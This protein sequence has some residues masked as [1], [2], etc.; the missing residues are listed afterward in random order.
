MT[1]MELEIAL[2]RRETAEPL[3]QARIDE[4]VATYGRHPTI[5]FFNNIT[6]R[7]LA[8]W[9]GPMDGW[10]VEAGLIPRESGFVLG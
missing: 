4:F 2:S 8:K 9:H 7:D 10:N 6:V 5:M 3:V 1:E